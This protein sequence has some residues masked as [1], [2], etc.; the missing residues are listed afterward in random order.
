MELIVHLRAT[1]GEPFADP[2]CYRHIVVSLVYLGFTRPDI[3]YYVH[4]LSQFVSAPTQMHYSH[5]FVFCVIFV[6]L[7]LVACSFL[8]PTLCSS[9]H[10]LMLLGLVIPLIVDLFLLIVFFLVVL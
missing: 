8:A 3:S 1:D 5:F 9:M 6:G 10:I 7:Y 4:I 2:T